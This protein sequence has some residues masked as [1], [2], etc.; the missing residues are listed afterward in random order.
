MKEEEEEAREVRV[1]ESET[2]IMINLY[3]LLLLLSMRR[4]G[5]RGEKMEIECWSEIL[6][7]I[8]AHPHPVTLSL[9][10]LIL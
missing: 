3:P 6:G 2:R 9:S 7:R 1:K 4:V 5:R 8:F 10:P